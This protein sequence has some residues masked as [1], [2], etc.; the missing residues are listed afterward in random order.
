MGRFR[1]L[2]LVLWVVVTTATNVMA[3]AMEP[4]IGI[5]NRT[6]CGKFWRL[7][8]NYQTVDADGETPIVLSAAIFMANDIYTKSLRAKGCGLVN[9]YTIT[10]DA[11]RPTNVS[12]Y[13]TMEGML[14][15]T[16]Y[17]PQGIYIING[18]KVI[19]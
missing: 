12:K 5:V 17:L 2:F 18:K 13:T 15:G 8:F 7:D 9:H 14:T 19:K 4:T 3:E 16:N 11:S 6:N 10:D 1:S